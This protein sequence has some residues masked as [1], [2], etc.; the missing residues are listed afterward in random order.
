MKTILCERE[1]KKN[2]GTVV[3]NFHRNVVWVLSLTAVTPGQQTRWLSGTLFYAQ[4]SPDTLPNN[5]HNSTRQ[6]VWTNPRRS[7]KSGVEVPLEAPNEAVETDQHSL[8]FPSRSVST[9]G[10]SPS[11]LT[12]PLP[13]AP[14]PVYSFT[15][16]LLFR[17]PG[18]LPLPWAEL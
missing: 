2:Q 6:W 12:P 15:L 11:P 10:P 4:I 13:E 8:T 9:T 16:P 18:V 14:D 7:S 5:Q 17:G 3:F 1:G